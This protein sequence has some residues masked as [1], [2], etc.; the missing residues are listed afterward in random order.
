MITN[1]PSTGT[2]SIFTN[3]IVA[4]ALSKIDQ[5]FIVR[6]LTQSQVV[7]NDVEDAFQSGSTVNV[8][9]K[10]ALLGQKLT[11]INGNLTSKALA[12]GSQSV[13]MDFVYGE[14][15]NLSVQDLIAMKN[16]DMDP[17]AVA[18][19]AVVMG[20]VRRF[21]ADMV[22][23]MRTASLGTALGLGTSKIITY[24]TLTNVRANFSTRGFGYGVP[25]IGVVHPV[26]FAQ[27]VRLAEVLS[28]Q[29]KVEASGFGTSK[30][31]IPSLNMTILESDQYTLSAV[32]A[33]PICTFQVEGLAV[34]PVRTVGVVDAQ[35]QRI[36]RDTVNSPAVPVLLSLS[37]ARQAGAKAAIVDAS[38]LSGFKF[39]TTQIGENGTVANNAAVHLIGELA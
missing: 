5:S 32:A 7:Q 1:F 2:A 11:D 30:I 35:N 29:N 27:I 22:N 17:M 21:E 23:Q 20:A 37:Y 4:N 31:Q 18:V 25:I 6:Y 36:V 3:K 34:A 33:D 38:F 15:V 28:N 39:L 13:E 9:I 14:S 16:G 12:F 24:S 26:Y 8:K 10:P 19:E